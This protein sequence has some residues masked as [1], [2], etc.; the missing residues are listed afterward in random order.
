[1]LL[2]FCGDVIVCDGPDCRVIFSHLVYAIESRYK[3]AVPYYLDRHSNPN[4]NYGK[5]HSEG[6]NDAVEC[7]GELCSLVVLLKYCTQLSL[8]GLSGSSSK[9]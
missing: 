3:G 7:N 6:S 2:T 4:H 1:M 9:I 5:R 8:A